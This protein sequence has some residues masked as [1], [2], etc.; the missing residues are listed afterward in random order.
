[1]KASE[2]H[3]WEV[4]LD[5][6]VSSLA[7][8]HPCSDGIKING[9]MPSRWPCNCSELNFAKIIF[10]VKQFTIYPPL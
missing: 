4:S 3:S 7:P 8:I 2:S 5:L 1:M 6:H 9:F 10:I